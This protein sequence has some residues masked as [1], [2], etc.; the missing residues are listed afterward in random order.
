VR[1]ERSRLEEAFTEAWG[2]FKRAL[3]AQT[4]Y[5]LKHKRRPPVPASHEADQ[6]IEA[7][8]RLKKFNEEHEGQEEE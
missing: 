2:R 7:W 4:A 3:E 8:E 6:V 1:A 5:Q